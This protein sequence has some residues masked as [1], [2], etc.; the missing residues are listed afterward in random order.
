MA[1]TPEQIQ[2]LKSQ[3]FSQIQH[4]PPDKKQQAEEQIKNMSAEAIESMLKQQSGPQK[5]IFRMIIDKEVESIIVDSNDEALAVLDIA[6]LSDGHTLII[7]RSAASSAQQIPGKAFELAQKVSSLIKE[8]LKASS[9]SI[10]TEMKFGESIIHV[11]PSYDSPVS[12][13]SKR[14]N[15]SQDEL[16][17]LL[18]KIKPEEQPKPIKIKKTFSPKETVK[19]QMRIP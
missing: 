13:D 7:P 5:S 1:L 16:K 15:S 18:K 3:L 2:E 8:N 19:R 6:P 9:V 12:L 10:Q 14:K 17:D 11:I 4:L